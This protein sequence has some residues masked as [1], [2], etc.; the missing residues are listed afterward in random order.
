ML[1]FPSAYKGDGKRQLLDLGCTFYLY[2]QV[3]YPPVMITKKCKIHKTESA[4]KTNMMVIQPSI[5]N[6][7]NMCIKDQ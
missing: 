6:S 3:T 4:D 2:V 1:K 7:E 5:L